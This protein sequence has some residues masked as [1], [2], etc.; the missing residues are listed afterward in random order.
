[1][2]YPYR[3]LQSF[4]FILNSRGDLGKGRREGFQKHEWQCWPWTQEAFP[5]SQLQEEMWVSVV[6]RLV[7]RRGVILV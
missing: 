6:C 3:Q 1:M 7:I 4:Y 5:Q 2:C